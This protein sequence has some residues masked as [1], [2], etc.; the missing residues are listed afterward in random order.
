MAL[1]GLTATP[2]RRRRR[3]FLYT[4]VYVIVLAKLAGVALVFEP[5]TGPSGAAAAL[6]RDSLHVGA[7]LALSATA[8]LAGLTLAPTGD[9]I[10]GVL[11]LRGRTMAVTVRKSASSVNQIVKEHI[12]RRGRC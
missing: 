9:P 4:L 12:S 1:G 11:P 3:T 5:H 2:R 10:A 7:L 8:C 6:L